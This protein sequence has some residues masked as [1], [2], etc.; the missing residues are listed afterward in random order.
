MWYETLLPKILNMSITGSLVIV[1]V[2]I[3]RLLFQKAPRI[4][5]YSLWVVVLF[6]LL[7][8]VTLSANFS[9]LN[10]FDVPVT[11]E[12]TIEYVPN[13]IVSNAFPKVD[14]LVDTASDAVNRTLPQGLE[15]VEQ[16][17]LT[18]IMAAATAVWLLGG[19][20][21]LMHSLY[22]L[23]LLRR[24]LRDAAL[25]RENIYV[26]HLLDT[27]IVMGIIRPRIYLPDG[28]SRTE[29]DHVLLH[30]DYHIRRGDHAVKLLSFA[31]LCIHWFNP[32]VWLAFYLADKDMEMS[33]DE[34]VVKDMTKD[35]RCD[36]SES[37]LRLSTG[38]RVVSA[39]PLSFCEGDPKGRIKNILSWK[40]PRLLT[41]VAGIS[42]CALLAVS[43][44]TDPVFAVE[45]DQPFQK[46]IHLNLPS[47]YDYILLDDPN[48]SGTGK[49]IIIVSSSAEYPV[50]EGCISLAFYPEDCTTWSGYPLTL[51]N[52]AE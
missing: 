46:R 35:M 17:P 28:L 48:H 43:L 23:F 39:G 20:V 51:D 9:A 25:L 1:L 24:K 7:C 15:Q 32:L 49:N 8:P 14:L 26:S 34:A 37:L 6:R 13:D 16:M 38:R 21:L 2:L 45:M 3:A 33:C 41:W 22:G 52:G 29:Q 42:T 31:A 12:Y 27:P 40:N 10:L 30:E 50:C 11:E 18:D 4:L 47:G 44:L 36:Y 19:L 5:A